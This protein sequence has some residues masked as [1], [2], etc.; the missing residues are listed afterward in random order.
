[1][2]ASTE[3]SWTEA[4]ER[5]LTKDH[6]IPMLLAPINA[7]I[8]EYIWN[9][10]IE[11]VAMSQASAVAQFDKHLLYLEIC[12]G[13]WPGERNS[14]HDVALEYVKKLRANPISR[15]QASEWLPEDEAEEAI[16]KEIAI[17]IMRQKSAIIRSD[18][19]RAA[20]RVMA[21]LAV[22]KPSGLAGEGEL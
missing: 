20:Q 18:F 13:D 11:S 12:L 7:E 21:L 5:F 2:S 19:R 10:A 4:Y 15:A 9:A 14:A 3:K 16:A 22:M 8:V 17:A 1:M 6:P